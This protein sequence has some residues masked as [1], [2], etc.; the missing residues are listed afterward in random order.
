MPRRGVLKVILFSFYAEGLRCRNLSRSASPA[1]E[2]H[3]AQPARQ[4]SSSPDL[5][6]DPRP[7]VGGRARASRGAGQAAR[8]GKP[9]LRARRPR[10]APHASTML[11]RCAAARRRDRRRQPG[12]AGA[13]RLLPAASG[14]GAE[15]LPRPGGA[16][17]PA[18]SAWRETRCGGGAAVPTG[19]PGHRGGESPPPPPPP[20]ARLQLPARTGALGSLLLVP[21][22]FP[23]SPLPSPG[24][25]G[26]G[27]SGGAPASFPPPLLLPPATPRRGRW[28]PGRVPAPPPHGSGGRD[29]GG[30]GGARPRP[31]A[32]GLA[33]PPRPGGGGRPAP[34]APSPLQKL[35]RQLSPG[36]EPLPAGP[37]DR[38]G[39]SRAGLGWAGCVGRAAGSKFVGEGP[40]PP[41]GPVPSRPRPLPAGL[42]W[43]CGAAARP[44][45]EAAFTA[46]AGARREPLPAPLPA[47]GRRM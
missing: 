42:R 31:P 2:A 1:R 22:P 6:R 12:S 33:P 17:I 47:R 32:P 21:P 36:P 4:R 27:R 8:Q 15:A 24:R 44:P 10:A 20:A 35:S 34:P 25:R 7:G 14:S 5:A 28:G 29:G 43:R 18:R 46:R 11:S 3:G 41:L 39:G 23:S 40:C 13:A 38:A 45:A 9:R 30:D 19:D 26:S 37:T 16:A